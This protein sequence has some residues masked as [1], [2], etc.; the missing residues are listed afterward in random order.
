M[1]F[2]FLLNI[3]DMSQ[4]YFC[5]FLTNSK[6]DLDHKFLCQITYYFVSTSFRNIAFVAWYSANVE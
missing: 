5:L 3:A 6:Q 2:V 1:I 4:I